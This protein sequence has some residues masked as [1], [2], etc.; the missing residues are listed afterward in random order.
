MNKIPQGISWD[1]YCMSMAFLA[2]CK[3]HDKNTKVG[4]VALLDDKSLYMGYNGCPSG[5]NDEILGTK[6][7]YDYVR[8]A[9]ENC[10]DFIGLDKCRQQKNL[11][12]YITIMPCPRCALKLA[13][14]NVKNIIYY[15]D[16]KS[17]V[18]DNVTLN[19]I[20]NKGYDES[21]KPYFNIKKY[22]GQKLLF[23]HNHFGAV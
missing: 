1:N 22:N 16:Y 7:K 13:H 9:E 5:F 18:N 4:C 6:E 11:T 15:S 17:E 23:I 2:S 21:V 12:L 20:T 8:H 14:F 19:K 10:L 3:S